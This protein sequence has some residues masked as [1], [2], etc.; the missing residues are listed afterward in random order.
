VPVARLPDDVLAVDG[1]RQRQRL[2]GEGRVDARVFK[3]G[4]DYFIDAK[5]AERHSVR[6]P[7]CRGAGWCLVAGLG[8]GWLS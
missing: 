1:Q 2:D 3:R 5:V 7:G 6:P 4:A 8:L